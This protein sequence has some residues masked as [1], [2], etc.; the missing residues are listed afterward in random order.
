MTK[1]K[2]RKSKTKTKSTKFFG[3]DSVPS[4]LPRNSK[5]MILEYYQ[6]AFA[7]FS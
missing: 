2:S 7:L 4:N 6:K 3:G 5:I 1:K